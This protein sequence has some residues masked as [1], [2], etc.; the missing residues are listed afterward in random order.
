MKEKFGHGR[1]RESME[2]AGSCRRSVSGVSGFM[3]TLTKVI[4]HNSILPYVSVNRLGSLTAI[5]SKNLLIIFILVNHLFH[6]PVNRSCNFY[7]EF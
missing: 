6:L 4:V 3:P 1:T 2:A 7:H 5:L